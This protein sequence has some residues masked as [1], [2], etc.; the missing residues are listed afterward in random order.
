V[1]ERDKTLAE[2]YPHY[3]K[4]VAHLKSVDVYRLLDLFGPIHPCAQH[5]IKKLMVAG[6]RGAKDVDVDL[7]EAIDTLRRWQ[8][9]RAEDAAELGDHA[10]KPGEKT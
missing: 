4:N 3:H 9:M 7:K 1:S 2:R 8:D 6:Q 5:A 10:A